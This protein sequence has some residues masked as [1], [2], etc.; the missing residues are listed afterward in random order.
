M[1]NGRPVRLGRTGGTR[2]LR[3]GKWTWSLR[4]G[5]YRGDRWQT[6]SQG[7]CSCAQQWFSND[8][9][10]SCLIKFWNELI[11][12]TY[13][14][15]G[16]PRG[17]HRVWIIV[18]HARATMTPAMAPEFCLPFRMTS[19]GR[20]GES[21]WLCFPSSSARPATQH[22][23]EY[24]VARYHEIVGACTCKRHDGNKLNDFYYSLQ[25]K[26]NC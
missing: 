5:L 2:S 13:R 3:S 19:S 23:D 16:M 20:N 24:K 11:F 9:P 15:Y 4:R 14:S 18:V 10:I 8:T 1:W 17:Y 22:A 21:V 6:Q 7:M 25:I 26:F 12:F